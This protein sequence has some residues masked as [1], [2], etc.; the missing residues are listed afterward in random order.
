MYAG[1]TALE[2]EDNDII[3]GIVSREGEVVKYV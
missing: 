3:T 1:I 2:S